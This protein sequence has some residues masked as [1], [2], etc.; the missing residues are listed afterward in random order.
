[1]AKEDSTSHQVPA[2][3]GTAAT[4]AKVDDAPGSGAGDGEEGEQKVMTLMEH[5]GELRTRLIRSILGIAVFFGLTVLFG[6]QIL[7]FVK[8]PL[9]RA[10]PIG[11]DALHYTNPVDVFMIYMKLGVLGGLVLGS[12]VWLYQFWRFVEPALYAKEKKYVRPFAAASIVLFL[13]G[14]SFCYFFVLPLALE[15]LI[16]LGGDMV[17]PIIA[18][19][20]YISLLILMVFGFGLVFEA[21]LILVLLAVLDVVELETLRKNRRMIIVVIFIIAAVATPPDPMSQTAMAIPMCLMF[22]LALIV[23]RI[24]KGKQKK[25]EAGAA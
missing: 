16:G 22:E 13:F 23:I 11:A 6:E 2:L 18:I 14:V 21:P 19:D 5:I 25:A 9:V 4:P 20:S 7:G 10:L 17:K 8:Q 3:S 24:I 12:P 15:Y 1:M